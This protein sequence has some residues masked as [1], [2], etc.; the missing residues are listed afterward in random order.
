MRAAQR[1]LVSG[2]IAMAVLACVGCQTAPLGGTRW[3]VLEYYGPEAEQTPDLTRLIVDFRKNGDL[4]TTST[5]QDGRVEVCNEKYSVDAPNHVITIDPDGDKPA[6]T[7]MY[8]FEKDHLR[9]HSERFIVVMEPHS[10]SD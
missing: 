9:V 5:F 4:I 7:S 8:R 6:I 1:R 10:E 3:K 2:T